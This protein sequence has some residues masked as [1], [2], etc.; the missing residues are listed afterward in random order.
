MQLE[1]EQ[2]FLEQYMEK[3]KARQF[4]IYEDFRIMEISNAQTQEKTQ[5]ERISLE[6]CLEM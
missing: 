5:T 3:I 4:F 6:T 2:K 1:K